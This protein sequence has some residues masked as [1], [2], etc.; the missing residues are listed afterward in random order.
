MNREAIETLCGDKVIRFV[1][2]K[3]NQW[4]QCEELIRECDRWDKGRTIRGF[5]A[6]L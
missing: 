1:C 4:L 6:A 3:K 5:Y 2:G